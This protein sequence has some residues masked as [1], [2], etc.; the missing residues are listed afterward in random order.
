MNFL[1]SILLWLA[2]LLLAAHFWRHAQI[3]LALI[4]AVLPSLLVLKRWPIRLILSLGL[5]AGLGL[6]VKTF[7]YLKN[8]YAVHNIPF[9]KAGFILGGVVVLTLLASLFNLY[10]ALKSRSSQS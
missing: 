10:Q 2:Y 7:Y 8:F 3:E 9:L 1:A 6:W 4:L 5:L